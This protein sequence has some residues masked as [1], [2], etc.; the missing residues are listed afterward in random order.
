M[1]GTRRKKI[2]P[3]RRRKTRSISISISITN[4]KVIVEI[5]SLTKRVGRMMKSSETE[6]EI[7]LEKMV[8][9]GIR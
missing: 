2:N 7:V 9:M 5:K 8:M 1:K 6:T 4:L 3:T